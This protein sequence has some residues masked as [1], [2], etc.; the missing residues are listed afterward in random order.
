M[1]LKTKYKMKPPQSARLNTGN[2]LADKLVACYLF[3]EGSGAKVFDSSGRGHHGTLTGGFTW[4]VGKYGRAV[5][6]DGTDGHIVIADSDDFSPE[7]SPFSISAWVYM[8][9]A[10]NFYIASKGVLA[11]DGEWLLRSYSDN[12]L[13][14]LLYDLSQTA[15]IGRYY[16]ESMAG[17]E[18]QWVHVVATYD[19]GTLN[20]G[21]K[22]YFKGGRVDD[23]DYTSGTFVAVENLDHDVW[24]GRY[25]TTY[26]EGLIDSLMIWRRVLTPSDIARLYAK[27]FCMF[28]KP[29][30]ILS[31]IIRAAG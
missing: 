27:P 30:G 15:Y 11:T 21:I 4:T 25:S 19:G 12:K 9:D 22:L 18:K 31:R 13:Y 14:F 24:L 1:L 23:N 16:N 28:E 8:T 5:E 29:A 2:P 3:N 26:A 17:F 7:R 6:L 20:E 10:T